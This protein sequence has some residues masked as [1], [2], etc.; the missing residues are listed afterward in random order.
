MKELLR[1]ENLSVDFTTSQG[2]LSA[3]RQFNL[4]LSEGE[5]LGL[6]GESGSGKSVSATAVLGLLPASARLSSGKI[7]WKGED[8]AGWDAH[9]WRSFRGLEVAMIFQEPGR[10]FDPLATIGA[11]FKETLLAHH[12]HVPKNEIHQ[13]TLQLLGE[14]RIPDPENRLGNYPHQFSGGMLQRVMIALALANSPQVLI[15]DEPTTALD[16][17]IQAQIIDLIKSLQKS[18]KL[19]V[20]FITHNLALLDRFADR[21]TVMYGGLQMEE[22]RT[23]T[24]LKTPLHPYTNLLLDSLIRPGDRP[25]N[26]VFPESQG[27]APDPLRLPLGCPFASRCPLAEE[28]CSAAIP[29]WKQGVRCRRVKEGHHA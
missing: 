29:E 25:G 13:R 6:V 3:V 1:I 7:L 10:S 22:A 21:I 9:R 15:A 23:D 2:N 27:Y 5:C 11:N 19:S 16:V 4:S 26:K 12:P 18:R 20:L 24:I 28:L 8:Q 17:T 14:V